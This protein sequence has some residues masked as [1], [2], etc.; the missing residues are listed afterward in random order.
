MPLSERVCLGLLDPTEMLGQTTP[1]RQHNCKQQPPRGQHVYDVLLKGVGECGTA[2]DVC[3]PIL[4]EPKVEV[5]N[6]IIGNI[7]R[8]AADRPSKAV[9]QNG[10]PNWRTPG[11]HPL[12]FSEV[13]R[14]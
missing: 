4:G 2:E 3:T 1:Q 6:L 5:D 7:V 13:P 12:R 14:S 8:R 11:P 9:Q 10:P